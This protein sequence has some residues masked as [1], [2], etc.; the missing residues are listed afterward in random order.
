MSVIVSC[1]TIGGARPVDAA[2]VMGCASGWSSSGK[3][4]RDFRRSRNGGGPGC[5]SAH[6]G[7]TPAMRRGIQY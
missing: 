5:P 7:T 2:P 1:E 6:P 4:R 3:S